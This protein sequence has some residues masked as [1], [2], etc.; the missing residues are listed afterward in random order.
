MSTIDRLPFETFTPPL[1][2]AG[3][4]TFLTGNTSYNIALPAASAVA[5]STGFTFSV[6]GVGAAVSIIPGSTDVIDLAPV[7]LRTDDRYH[8]VS[9]GNS[10]W[11]DVFRT[12]SVPPTL[13]GPPVPPS[14][15]V[16]Q[17]PAGAPAGSLAFA[18]NSRTSTEA[19]GAG[20]GVGVLYDGQLG[21]STSVGGTVAV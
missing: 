3:N 21:I 9:D 11:H 10:T 18:S 1:I 2:L 20:T 5:A 17:L 8:I 13:S 6:A 15:S 19:A 16:G 4:I 7:V 14:Y 12:N